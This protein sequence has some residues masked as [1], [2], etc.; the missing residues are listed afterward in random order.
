MADCKFH[1]LA[2]MC[3]CYAHVLFSFP[4]GYG[5]PLSAEA[6][7]HS[8]R[9]YLANPHPDHVILKLGFK[10]AINSIRR[11]KCLKLLSYTYCFIYFLLFNFFFPLFHH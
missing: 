8:A 1:C 5:T 6:D 11:D 9:R 4:L 2:A 3:A 7:G 10:N